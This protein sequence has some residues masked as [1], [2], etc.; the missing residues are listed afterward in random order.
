M[1]VLSLFDGMSCGQL[2]L[3]RA[4]IK[5]DKYYASEIDKYA[6]QITQKNYPQTIQLGDIRNIRSRELSKIHLLIG[7]SPCQ[8]FSFEGKQLNFQDPRSKLFFEFVRIKNECNPDIFLLENVKMKKEYQDIISS[9][10]GVEPIEINSAL[11]S[12][13]NRRRLYWT[14]LSIQEPE[15]R[16]IYLDDILDSDIPGILVDYN[17]KGEFSILAKNKKIVRLDN[18]TVYPHSIHASVGIEE[19][20][21]AVIG[22]LVKL[23]R[24][25][26]L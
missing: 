10:L 19:I 26:K 5:V 2:A 1:N 9:Y 8:G 11:C 22:K 4:G 15:D 25:K 13:Q 14:N 21:R 20:S 16:S 23:E 24:D 12:A 17:Q 3:R 6:I 7:G 18:K